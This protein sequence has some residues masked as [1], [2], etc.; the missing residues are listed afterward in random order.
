MNDHL[1]TNMGPDDWIGVDLDGTFAYYDEWMKWNVIGKPIPL[2]VKRVKEFLR[3][4]LTV[5]VFTARVAYGRDVCKISREEFTREM[6]QQIIGE[7]TMQT[8]NKALESTAIKTNFCR[9]IW[10]DRAIQVV[11]NTG[12]TLSE[13]YEAQIEA[14]RGKP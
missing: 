7:W 1:Y 10:D 3:M 5:K 2:M 13:E 8:V 11:P 12:R 4:G 9:E 14:L 6:M